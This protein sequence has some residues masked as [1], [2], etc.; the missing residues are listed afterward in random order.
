MVFTDILAGSYDAA[1]LKRIA[2]PYGYVQR[3]FIYKSPYT[4]TTLNYGF[5]RSRRFLHPLFS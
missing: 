3:A 2:Q 5:G 4:G 1:D